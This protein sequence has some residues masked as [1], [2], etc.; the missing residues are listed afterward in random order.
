M[1]DGFVFLALGAFYVAMIVRLHL[2]ANYRNRL[3]KRIRA[4]AIG[5]A[6][7]GENPAWRWSA[8]RR[9]TVDRMVLQF[10]RPISSFYDAAEREKR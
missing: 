1:T 8:F 2:I 9:V 3:H 10:W 4:A 5:D 7:R 6:R